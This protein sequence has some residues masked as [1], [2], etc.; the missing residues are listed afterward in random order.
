MELIPYPDLLRIS[1]WLLLLLLSGCAATPVQPPD[2][3]TRECRALFATVDDTVE[4]A[5]VRDEGPRLI[6]GF[7]YL[8]VDRFLAS[9]RN[10]VTEPTRFAAWSKRLAQLDKQARGYEV[11]NL[12]LEERL[13]LDGLAAGGN[14][15]AALDH[16]RIRLMQSEL[17]LAENRRLLRERAIMPDDY[18]TAWR[19]LG[20][21]PLTAPFV[22]IGV[23]GWH[24]ETRRIY[25]QP[26]EQL[27]IA[28]KLRIWAA[29][30]APRLEPAAVAAILH[31]S[32]DN[33][34]GIPEPTGKQRDALFATFAP[35]WHIDTLTDDDLPGTPV[36]LAGETLAQVDT[37]RP[38]VFRRLSHTRFDGEVL[39][40]LNYIT[41]FKSRPFTSE[42]DI[43]AGAFDGVNF[44]V[45]LNSDGRP[46]L[47][48][49][50]HNCGCY[51]KYFPV[52]P[53]ARNDN[54]RDYWSEPPLVP[55]TLQH[56]GTVPVLHLANR[57]HYVDR[58]SFVPAQY[59]ERY[60]WDDYARL[61]SLALPGG[62][63]RSLFDVHGILLGSERQERSL[64]WPM[65]I[66]SP[67]AMRQWGRH[68][69]AFVGRRHFD[70]PYLI[71]TLF[72]LP[73]GTTQ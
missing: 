28:G 23:N 21:Y 15:T 46:L 8:R 34:L 48:D 18:V 25:A 43:Y 47:F 12:Q 11:A 9:F 42:N 56:V 51:H 10:E 27:P 31:A 63:R 3:A 70:D 60:R 24:E 66:R 17:A 41:W 67:G 68:A 19:V 20:L 2:T 13:R 36:Y 72:E 40:Q 7:P 65:G 58:I 30:P 26:L 5:R 37:A 57:T 69:V 61:R 35:Q 55:Q 33:P 50:V 73:K 14:L 45:T 1:R 71:E 62:E 16:C 4:A 52:A 6:P 44:R 32:A 39:L 59:A 49:T 53:L 64:L 54:E 22:K 38:A 29:P